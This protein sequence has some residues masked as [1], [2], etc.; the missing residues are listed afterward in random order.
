LTVDT[1]LPAAGALGDGLANPTTPMIG[2][3]MLIYNSSTY[4][5]VVEGADAG[6]VLV[7]VC[8]RAA[9]DLGKVDVAVFDTAITAA[10]ATATPTTSPP[11][12]SF[13][14]VFNGTNWDL[15]REGAAGAGS[16]LVDVGD[17]AA[18]QVGIVDTELP[19]AAA[20]QDNASNPTTPMVG[21][22]LMGWETGGSVW[23]RVHVDGSGNLAVAIIGAGVVDTELPAAAAL[24]DGAANPTTPT[25]GAAGLVWHPTGTAWDRVRS[26]EE[27][28]GLLEGV[29]VS[30]TYIFNGTNWD[31]AREG[32][33]AGSIFVDVTDRAA[34]VVGIVDTEL[35]AAIALSDAYAN[36]TTAPVG[37]FLMGFDGT[38]WERVRVTNTGQLHTDIQDRAARDL[39]KVDIADFDDAITAADATA[40]PTTSPPV[41]SFGMVFNGTNWDL[42]REGAIAGSV[43]ADTELPAAAALADGA[44]NPTTPM[45]GSNLMVW[46]PTGTDWD[47]AISVE[48]GDAAL[49]GLLAVGGYVYNGATWDRVAEG[50]A[51]AGS[52]LTDVADRAGRLL[53]IA[54]TELVLHDLDTTGATDNQ[55]AVGLLLESAAGALVVGATNPLPISDNGGS[56]TVDGSVTADTE[57]PAAG[58]LADGLANPTT[59]MVGA[60]GLIF[61]N[62][63][64]DRVR[65]GYAPGS[66]RVD[67]Y[68][69]PVRA[70]GTSA[71]NTLQT[72][73]TATEPCKVLF[74]TVH[75]SAAVTQ[76]VT[77]TLNAGAGAGYDTVLETISLV[78]AQDGVWFPD[79]D[80]IIRNDDQLDVTAPAG[81]AG[82]TSAIMIYTQPVAV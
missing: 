11:V 56:L 46:N 51:A 31:A 42:M 82:V 12:V 16:V 74:V 9:R 1:E 32:N 50:A 15:I 20:L 44:A 80:V 7:D 21:A 71:A 26:A 14:M 3:V 81:G 67:P 75:F 72:V 54:D 76:D 64:Y 60:V 43:I 17:R 18:R 78:N 39:G 36:P 68:Y 23:D 28:D 2:S 8:S 47:R 55:A 38:D 35:A 69:E 79:S 66:V 40:T 77:C 25:V 63:T 49:A 62:A 37:A 24:A 5:R 48:K 59:P 4:D 65:E 6:S 33:V 53:G 73:S 29:P 34:R 61:N 13:G 41:V 19:A 52:V 70:I 22:C 10:D 45:V 27:G 58:A 30:G 57:L